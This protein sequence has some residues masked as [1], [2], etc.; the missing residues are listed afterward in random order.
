MAEQIDSLVTEFTT[1]KFPINPKWKEMATEYYG[2]ILNEKTIVPDAQYVGMIGELAF[3]FFMRCCGLRAMYMGDES[4]HYDFEVLDKKIDIKTCRRDYPFAGNYEMKIPAYQ[5]FQECDAYVFAN[6]YG[7][8]IELLG[9]MPK[10]LFWDHENGADRATGE[11][12]G[13]YKY[14]KSCRVLNAGNLIHMDQFGGFLE[15]Q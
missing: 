14:K 13:G 2:N 11:T 15:A 12:F 4:L 6:I 5:R 10:H 9:Y 8:F 7:E 1:V 3:A